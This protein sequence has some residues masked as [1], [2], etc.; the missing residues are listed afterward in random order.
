MVRAECD[1]APVQNATRRTA[2]QQKQSRVRKVATLAR[3]GEKGRALAAARNAP[4]PVTEQTVQEIKSLYPTDP[5]PPGSRTGLWCQTCSCQRSQNSSPPLFAECQD[6]A[7]LDLLACVLSVWY[8]FGSLAGNNNL[9]VQVV[10]HVAAAPVP[11]SVPQYVKAGQ[12][13]PLAK[14]TS[15]HRPLL[16]MSLLRRLG[17]QISQWQRTRECSGEMCGTFAVRCWTTRR[18]KHDDQNHTNTSRRLTTP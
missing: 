11:H 3:T 4:V 16:M 6:S 17:T 7:S 8:D 15:G 18:S 1:I 9:F 12:I 13:T 5:E 14:P 10:A 2:T